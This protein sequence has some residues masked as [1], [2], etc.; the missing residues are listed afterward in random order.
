MMRYPPQDVQSYLKRENVHGG[1]FKKDVLLHVALAE[2]M[3]RMDMM[4]VTQRRQK[5]HLKQHRQQTR[6]I[7]MT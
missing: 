2:K 6:M 7:Q 4:E 3:E 1:L 5:L